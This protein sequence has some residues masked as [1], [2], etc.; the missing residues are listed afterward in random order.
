MNRTAASAC[1]AILV[2]VMGAGVRAQTPGP[3][4]DYTI[5]TWNEKDGLP[6]GRIWSM[7]QDRDGYLWLGTDAGLVRFDGVRFVQW[8]QLKEAQSVL[9]LVGGRD[10]SIWA[11]FGGT[12]GVA[13][14]H[15]SQ[16][17]VYGESNGI[18][19]GYMVGLLED[20]AG[21][22]WAA[23][24]PGLHRFRDGRWEKIGPE[25]GL[26]AGSALGVFEDS[27][28][29]LWVATGE[30]V[31]RSVDRGATFEAVE[32]LDGTG[33]FWP[34]FS[35]DAS[36]AIW[37]TDVRTGFRRLGE[38]PVGTGPLHGRGIQ[39]LHDRRRQ[40]WV[41]TLGQG[42]WRVR[43]PLSSTT[44]VDSIT[45]RDGLSSDTV[46]SIFEDREGNVW[47]GTYAGLH[48]FSPR[49]VMPITDLGSARAV[50]ATADGSVWIATNAG[51]ARVLSDGSRERYDQRHGLPS[52][53]VS[54][55]H[56]D[57]TGAIWA[58]TEAGIVRFDGRRFV[59]VHLP[60]GSRVERVFSVTASGRELWLRD[61]DLGLFRLLDGRV[62]PPTEVP[63]AARAIV[64]AVSVDR[65]GNV[66]HG[67]EDGRLG[68]IRPDGAF[69][70]YEPG[71]GNITAIYQSRNGR[72]W[73]GGSGGLGR[74]AGG[75][76]S[77][78]TRRNGFPG[79]VASVIEDDEGAL[80]LGLGP[81]I[82]R[83]DP[84][85]FDAAIAHPDH[86]IRYRLFDTSDGVAGGP[87]RI[88]D[89]SV[90]KSRDGRL[91]FLTGAGLT[92]VDPRNLGDE[93]PLPPVRIESLAADGL[94]QD[95]TSGLR[96]SSATSHVVINF[97]ALT[98]ANPMKVRFRYRLEGFNDAWVDSGGS[99]QASYANL[100]PRDYRFTVMASN[101]PGEWDTTG[102]VVTFAIAPKFYQTGWFFA[103]CLVAAAST[104]WGA[105]QLRTRQVRRQYAMVLDERIRM[106]RAIHDTLLQGL[107]GIA[108][109]LSNL[110]DRNGDDDP[111][112]VTSRELDE[113]RHQAEYYI[114]EAR[115]SIWD[116]RSPQL[117]TSDF[118][119]ALKDVADRAVANTP[120]ELDFAVRG[121]SPPMSARSE[122]QS[123]LIAREAILN[124][125]RHGRARRVS[126]LL[127]CLDGG[128]RLAISDDGC[129]FDLEAA[130][131]TNT[132]FGLK[133][134]EERAEQAAA[135]LTITTSPGNGTTVEI[136]K[137]A[138]QA[139]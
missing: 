56:A 139:A 49:R 103:T 107:V 14:V 55:L 119:K 101:R 1:T 43:E 35:E 112:P 33:N 122:E 127:D 34:K 117:D 94:Q 89:P 124:A 114:R 118:T 57:E 95:L 102:A 23:G 9:S 53:I 120:T 38:G 30:M 80:W 63:G 71:I 20:D 6:A 61:L 8:D 125:V 12:G 44:R 106:S 24:R 85:E 87:L 83:L 65:E 100:R 39:L 70:S 130:R 37:I 123:L 135:R 47:V 96:L 115:Q 52:S 68:I 92:V 111:E 74:F 3:F 28:K 72:V 109:N 48:R 116:L 15:E 58:A 104:V 50:T 51:V 26:A 79:N 10:G 131:R 84:R 31:Y 25:R 19:S 128:M 40:L 66:W 113:V 76:F 121:I 2:I 132:H 137:Q 93:L 69:H 59:R 27:R 7:Q 62:W 21:T 82:V 110:G 4:E 45:A 54:A 67:S 64:S 75:A 78:I 73:I 42:L 17:T 136:L 126:V 29:R 91:W 60:E 133:S 46:R 138:A 108:L 98:L 5:S 88:A 11:G 77:A 86:A 41:A 90:A 22:I 134:M 99:R 36:G 32:A 16:A 97:T 105:W 129:G 81:G 13:R 18:D